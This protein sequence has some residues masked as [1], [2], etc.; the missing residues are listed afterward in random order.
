M[1]Q[2]ETPI[3]ESSI[4]KPVDKNTNIKPQEFHNL[5]G[6]YLKII[7]EYRNLIITAYDINALDG[8]KYEFKKDLDELRSS[9]DTFKYNSIEE[10][11][12]MIIK[13]IENGKYNIDKKENYIILSL[14]IKESLKLNVEF[15]LNY[16][17]E[18]NNEYIE[19]LSNEIR[20]LRNNNKLINE[21]KEE[22]KKIRLEIEQLKNNNKSQTKDLIIYDEK[23]KKYNLY[24]NI[25]ELNLSDK[26]YNNEIIEYL[27]NM[28][29]NELKTLLLYKNNITDITLLKNTKMEKLEKLSLHNNQISDI[30]VLEKV[31]YKELKILDLNDNMI[32]DINSLVNSRFEQLEELSLHSNKISDISILGKVNFKK[33]KQLWL[34]NNE[35]KDINCFEKSYFEHLELLN[36]KDNKISDINV[37]KKVHFE[38]LKE[39][40]LSNNKIIDIK[41][42]GSVSFKNLETLYLDGNE[43]TDIGVVTEVNFKNLKNLNLAKNKIKD[44][45]P[46]GKAR[47]EILEQL[48]L[49]DNEISDIDI[50]E[51]VNFPELKGLYLHNNKISNIQ[52]LQNIKSSSLFG[53]FGNS[54]LNNLEKL[55]LYDNQIDKSNNS[56]IL[57]Y[58]ELNIEDFK[59]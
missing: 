59:I 21:I 13:L 33:L 36:V 35:I 15:I 27:I 3:M 34:Y 44:I 52:S 54:I 42:L 18:V 7:N 6:F 2:R 56:K 32:S 19:I 57:D 5:N 43:I 23:N 48:G 4:N 55:Y 45:N 49:N 38:K 20:L 46:L 47:F 14:V 12:Q 58:L 16:E 11:L 1:L 22:S 24:S 25:K 30:S 53:L 8:K 26:N 17:E 28:E 39:L 29:L 37:F 51:K 40:V 31:N 9:Y 50:I 41:P 10:I